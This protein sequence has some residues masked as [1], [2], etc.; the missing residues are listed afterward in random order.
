MSENADSPAVDLDRMSVQQLTALIAAA[1]A[2]QRDKLDDARAALRAEME[3][4]AAELGI[5]LGDLFS[6]VGQQ[7]P[8]EQAAGKNGGARASRARTS[9]PSVRPNTAA[10]TA[11]NGRDGAGR[12]IGWRRWRRRAESERN[13]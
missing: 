4:K 1:E 8:A 6:A 5:A 2:K 3:Q 10:R 7:A 9:A 12:P 11:K 13:S